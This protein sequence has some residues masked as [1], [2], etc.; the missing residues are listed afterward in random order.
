[1]T[2]DNEQFIRHAYKIAENKD[3]EGWVAAFT[4]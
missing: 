4:S 3:V 2:E 1:M